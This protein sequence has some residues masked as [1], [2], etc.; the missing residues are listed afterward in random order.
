MEIQ[1]YPKLATNSRKAF[2]K[3]KRR[4][5]RSYHYKPRGDLLERL[6]KETGKTIDEVHEQL[7][8]ER[9]I[10]LKLKGIEN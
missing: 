3:V 2:L 9:A 8:R 5:G 4:Y 7:L 6:S 1:L 10:L